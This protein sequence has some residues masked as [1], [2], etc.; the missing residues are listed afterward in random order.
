MKLSA[1]NTASPFFSKELKLRRFREQFFEVHAFSIRADEP[2]SSTNESHLHPVLVGALIMLLVA[3]L[4]NN[5]STNP[6]RHY[7]VYWL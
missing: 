1:G 3:L 4:V 2:L 7:P 6:K 5:L